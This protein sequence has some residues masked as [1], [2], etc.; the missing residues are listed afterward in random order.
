M[1]SRSGSP[2]PAAGGPPTLVALARVAELATGGPERRVESLLSLRERQR[3][4]AVRH[5]GRRSEWLA[6]RLVAKHAFLVRFARTRLGPERRGAWRPVVVFISWDDLAASAAS[7]LAR[8]EVLGADDGGAG[9]P[10]LAW[11]GRDMSG[12]VS[13]SIAHAGGW[14]AVALSVQAPVGVDLEVV[15]ARSAAFRRSCFTDAEIAWAEG[16]MAVAGV[17]TDVRYT[18]LWTIKEAAFKTGRVGD[19][20]RP[21]DTELDLGRPLAE[22][23]SRGPPGEPY[24]VALDVRF[25]AAGRDRA[26]CMLIPAPTAPVG[27]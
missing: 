4:V 9:R 10:E 20:W 13:V 17:A 23:W 24:L 7:D 25:T 2:E 18:L 11:C 8:V 27:G 26:A 22:P 3:W 14:V 5:A 6:A 12:V 19:R 15:G 16:G 1:A 21:R